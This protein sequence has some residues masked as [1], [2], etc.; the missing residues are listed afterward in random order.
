MAAV[1]NSFHAEKFCHLV[2]AHAASARRIC[3][4]VL[5]FLIRSAF[6]LAIFYS[7]VDNLLLLAPAVIS[8]LCIYYVTYR[9]DSSSFFYLFDGM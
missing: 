6:V 2:S 1:T 5:Q 4:S 7:C 3:S 9:I 8:R